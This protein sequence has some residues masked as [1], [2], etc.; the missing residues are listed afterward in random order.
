[1]L[2][3]SHSGEVLFFPPDFLAICTPSI[4]GL[5]LDVSNATSLTLSILIENEKQ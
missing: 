3:N 1:M 5:N 4:W 2:Q